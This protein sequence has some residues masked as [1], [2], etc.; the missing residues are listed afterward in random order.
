MS[1]SPADVKKQIT[2]PRKFVESLG[3]S[4]DIITEGR[5]IKVRC[6]NHEDGGRPNLQISLRGDT[7]GVYCFVCQFGGDVYH[8]AEKFLGV[9]WKE[10]HARLQKLA[11][12]AP[13]IARDKDDYP[14]PDE[15]CR[16]W[17]HAHEVERD[18]ELCAQLRVRGIEPGRIKQLARA[19]PEVGWVPSW[20]W[21]KGESGPVRWPAAGYRLLVAM[22]TERGQLVTLHCRRFQSD[23]KIKGRFPSKCLAK[24]AMMLNPTALNS[25]TWD[26][27]IIVEGVPNWLVLA[28]EYPDRPVIGLVAG[29]LHGVKFERIPRGASGILW[30][31][32]DSDRK[33]DGTPRH[34]AGQHYRSR[35]LALLQGRRVRVVNLPVPEGA[36]KAPDANDVYVRGD[37][38]QVMADATAITAPASSAAA[39]LWDMSPGLCGWHHPFLDVGLLDELIRL[40]DGKP[41]AARYNEFGEMSDAGWHADA[42]GLHWLRTGEAPAAGV[43]CT[44]TVENFMALA[45]HFE[46]ARVD[47]DDPTAPAL[48]AGLPPAACEK[49]TLWPAQVCGYDHDRILTSDPYGAAEKGKH[50]VTS[51]LNSAQAVRAEKPIPP[52]DDKPA[53]E[54]PP[55]DTGNAE[56]LA[57]VFGQDIRFVGDWNQFLIWDGQRWA[58][59]RTFEIQRRAI[60]TARMMTGKWALESESA[61]KQNAM[62][63]MVRSQPGIPILPESMDAD[64][65]ALNIKNGTVDLRTGV[66]LPH[67]RRQ[68]ITKLAPVTFS[69]SAKCPKWLAFLDTIFAGNENIISFVQR[70]AGYSLTGEV[71]EHVLFLLFGTGRNGKSTFISVMQSL[72]GDYAKQASPDMLMGNG[73]KLDAGQLSG[74]A[75]LHGARFVAAAETEEGGK[76]GEAAC[77]RI[78][79]GDLIPAKYM[80]KDMFYFFPTHK[81]WLATNH[82]PKTR[83]NDKGL[84]SMLI[85]IPFEVT[86]PDGQIDRTLPAKLHAELSGILNWAIA[87]ALEWQR[88]GKLDPPSEIDEAVSKYKAE[89]DQLAPFLD[90]CCIMSGTVAVAAINT[91]YEMWCA[92]TGRELMRGYKHVMNE[93]FKAGS[94]GKRRWREGVTLRAEWQDRIEARERERY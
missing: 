15:V 5:G 50:A 29:S 40:H 79:K 52:P 63:S 2:D 72:L 26:N 30:T 62:C 86:I 93:R 67:D 58:R 28:A 53:R 54:F 20:A 44:D 47:N 17:D 84:W 45:A 23:D 71:S 32:S 78:T 49:L 37:L 66:L 59:D 1:L 46:A 74:I 33:P 90:E 11:G 13:V 27:F 61:G 16:F 57:Y 48:I 92:D 41:F 64:K 56:R 68:L 88:R 69:A 4:G 34:T 82:K 70:A 76:L 85:P 89:M 38:A 65:F 87:G 14:P 55:T 12:D 35:A 73:D 7:L 36:K 25:P 75:S 42:L 77:K 94:D 10:A 31:D 60:Y 3:Y 80:G 8:Y 22:Y 51:A 39:S 83:S 24:G 9:D 81:T 6:P 91:A 18:P 43:L 21:A 19:V